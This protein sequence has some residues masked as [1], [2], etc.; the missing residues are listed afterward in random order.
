MY[1]IVTGSIPTEFG[2]LTNLEILNLKHNQLD[3]TLP[4]EMGK[5]VKLRSLE[6]G[7]NLLDGE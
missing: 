1:A 2:D 7:I 5:L 3:G 4:T 6:L